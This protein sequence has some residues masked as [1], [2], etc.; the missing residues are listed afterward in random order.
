MS[1]ACG[2]VLRAIAVPAGEHAVEVRYESSTLCLGTV[3]S[4]SADLGLLAL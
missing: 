1:A 2:S 3:I 4:L